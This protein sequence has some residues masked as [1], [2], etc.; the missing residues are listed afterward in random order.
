MS[1]EWPDKIFGVTEQ[2]FQSLAL[3]IFRF[4]YDNCRVYNS[5]VNA[6]GVDPALVTTLEQIPFLPVSFFKNNTI[7]SGQFEAELIFESSGTTQTHNSHHHIKDTALY[8]KSFLKNFISQ[9]GNPADPIDTGWCVLG[10]LPSYLER[11]NSS[12]VFMVDCLIK[13]SG[14]PDSG[15]YLNEFEN[16]QATL[17]MLEQKKQKTLLIGVTYALL[18]FAEKF[19]M[20]LHHTVVMETGGMKGRREELTR[21][22]VHERLKNAF[23]L[24]EIH[25]E[26]GMTELLSQAYAKS[27]GRFHC[28]PW[29]KI[30]I[31][32]DED[33]FQVKS[34][35][36]I[37]KLFQLTTH[38]SPLTKLTGIINIIDLANVYSCSFLATDD[39]G[40]LYPDGSFEVLGRT[41]GSDLRGCSL[42]AV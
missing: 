29:M 5:F 1:C 17:K 6:L 28:P 26:Y 9:Y 37:G 25:S 23:G 40:R 19:P 38:D 4:Q 8:K 12:L 36:S 16:L 15:F 11:N 30:L 3:D 33:P 42:L 10:L 32:D 2:G 20:Q 13:E 22:E 35:E 21:M 27:E 18:D 41:D 31:R 7:K 39:A 14:N 34:Q 24:A